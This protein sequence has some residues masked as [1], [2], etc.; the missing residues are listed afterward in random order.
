MGAA[1]A[2]VWKESG[3]SPKFPVKC[4]A[5]VRLKCFF[6]LFVFLPKEKTKGFLCRHVMSL[7]NG[8]RKDSILVMPTDGVLNID[9]SN[10]GTKREVLF[11]LDY[12]DLNFE[13]TIINQG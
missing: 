13:Y 11:F 1:A 3:P 6:F 5:K 7:V 9:R 8:C 4:K 10:A 2:S 12:S